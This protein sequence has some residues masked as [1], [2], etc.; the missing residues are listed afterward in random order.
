MSIFTVYS[1]RIFFGLITLLRMILGDTLNRPYL[2]K[3]KTTR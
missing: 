1:V 2:Y 3:I